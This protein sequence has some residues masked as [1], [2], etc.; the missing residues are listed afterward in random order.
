MTHLPDLFPV[1]ADK[2]ESPALIVLGSP[3]PVTQLAQ[4]MV[5]K[6]VHA[7]QMDLH[8]AAVLKLKL[9]ENEAKA[10]VHVAADLWDVP[11][12]FRTLIFPAAAHADRELKIDMVEQ[13]FHLLEDG[14]RFVTLSEYEKDTQFAGWH[15]KVFGKCSES[16]WQKDDREK[17]KFGT[18]F[19]SVKA[20][21]RPRRRHE[22]TY[23][24]KVGD[25]A[26]MSFASW[27]G[28][29]SYGR[30]DDGS[31]AMLEVAAIKPGDKVV[32]MGCGNGA[33][34]CLASPLAGPT[35]EITFVDSNVRAVALTDHN[36]KLNGVT[37]YKLAATA[38]MADLGDGRLR[39]GPGEPAVLR[40]L[41]RRPAVH[42]VGP[43]PT[44]TRR[45]VLPRHEDAGPDDPRGGRDVRLGRVGREPR[46]HGRRRHG[47]VGN[48]A[49][50]PD[51]DHADQS[52][53]I[54]AG[55]GTRV[56]FRSSSS[57]GFDPRDPRPVFV[58]GEP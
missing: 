28:T 16:M 34:G 17:R 4:L 41:G 57:A 49:D 21:D 20:G 53:R 35:G 3:W 9:A 54:K 27:P 10:E 32:D 47:V 46:V 43:R 33:V 26:S 7:Y 58:L 52:P 30:M 6:E 18:A 25:G 12:K 48:N 37:N 50:K 24:A 5:G 19:W 51:A 1:V 40:E 31:R 56:F 42:P 11:K 14:G 13:G 45:E 39:R 55:I 8:Q 2:V 36:A 23:H 38:T 29:F 15:K 22:V 44:Q